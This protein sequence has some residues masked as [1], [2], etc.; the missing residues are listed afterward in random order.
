MWVFGQGLTEVNC[1]LGL[2]LPWLI[3]TWL[4]TCTCIW[5]IDQPW[6]VELIWSYLNLN[7][8]SRVGFL[9]AALPALRVLVCAG[10][11]S[12]QAKSD[13]Q[14][15]YASCPWAVDGQGLVLVSPVSF[16]CRWCGLSAVGLSTPELTWN[17]S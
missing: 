14:L 3:H 8:T 16:G 17:V 11:D 4:P 10:I 1:E 9:V 2:D 7:G 13:R 15:V 12:C 6:Y 5:T